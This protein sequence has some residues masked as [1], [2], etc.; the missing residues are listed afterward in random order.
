MSSD[1]GVVIVL[2]SAVSLFLTVGIGR[3]ASN[4]YKL[5]KWNNM[6]NRRELLTPIFNIYLLA[7][8]MYIFVFE[9]Y[10]N[11]HLDTI[12][13]VFNVGIAF[14]FILFHVGI[15]V[16]LFVSESL[17]YELVHGT[18]GIRSLRVYES[19]AI[20][21]AAVFGSFVMIADIDEGILSTTHLT[22]TFLFVPMNFIHLG[23]SMINAIFI[24]I[25]NY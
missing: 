21:I 9:K 12:N 22:I 4:A 3:E 1:Y 25:I 19:S 24:H 18:Q 10:H 15:L 11:Q 13:F 2:G 20:M 23:E 5:W 17:R 14:N 6:S 8:W 7:L 16:S